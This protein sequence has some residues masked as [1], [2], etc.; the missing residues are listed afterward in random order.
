[1][2]RHMNTKTR[3]LDV[4]VFQ[5]LIVIQ[6]LAVKDEANLYDVNSFLFLQLILEPQHLREKKGMFEK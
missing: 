4:A 2:Y 1:M 6:L 5:L 3:T